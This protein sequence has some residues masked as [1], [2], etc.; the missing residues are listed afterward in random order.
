[1][2]NFPSPF[3]SRLMKIALIVM[4]VLTMIV[5]AVF[6]IT[7]DAVPPSLEYSKIIQMFETEQV[8]SF[9]LTGNSLH[10]TLKEPYQESTEF[11]KRLMDVDLFFD[12]LG[13][14]IHRQLA[15]GTLTEYDYEASSA[16]DRF[17]IAKVLIL[18]L[19]SG[20][21]MYAMFRKNGPMAILADDRSYAVDDKQ[22]KKTFA[23]VAGC[24]EE[25]RACQEIVDFLKKPAAY[26][27]MGARLPKGVLLVGPPGTG[28]TLMAKAVAGEAGVSFLSVS[29]AE[30]EEK[31]VGVGASR[32]RRLFSEAKKKAPA[33][34][35]IDEIDAIGAARRD[36]KGNGY[37]DS[38]QT[39]NQLLTE[40]DGFSD[41]EGIVVMAAT[42]RADILDKALLRSGRFDRQMY[43]GLPDVRE[44]EEILHIHALNKPL[45]EEIDLKTVACSTSGF[46]GADLEKLLNEAAILAVRHERDYITSCD[47]DDAILKI[48]VGL[49]KKGR[50]ISHKER[51]LTAYHE[52]GHAIAARYLKHVDPVHYITIVPRGHVGGF[53]VTRPL[54]DRT[55]RM[56]SDIFEQIVMCLGG[57]TAETM[58]FGETS[59]G[60]AEDIRQATRLV[61]DMVVQ[62][63]MSD[64]LG[65]ICLT[66]IDCEAA[67]LNDGKG[68][69]EE[70]ASMID[71]E[72]RRIF[73][74]ASSH[75]EEIL[76]K[77]RRLL[78]DVAEYLLE[79]E[80]MNGE[81][82]EHFCEHGAPP[83]AGNT[84]TQAC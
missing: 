62:Y 34:V 28:K 68:Y 39:L 33:I 65:P 55:V 72:I 80:T 70:T 25:K 78:I 56:Q 84:K 37:S 15:D 18:L 40:M 23:D 3:S 42:N 76:K 81:E 48:S 58:F 20:S 64:C 22:K 43:I 4:G 63:G 9:S 57:R 46:S 53:M 24:D 47:V 8:D 69:S 35:F 73:D 75:C 83:E 30:F 5:F 45:G 19:L 60:A 32:V 11:T 10:L 66:G 52:A 51:C 82:F 54:E 67:G 59:T 29:G 14:T 12:D 31:Y 74:E 21:F 79:H 26:T 27:R 61:R 1:M 38:E 16:Q 49:Q 41:G 17:V 2:K 13:D 77:H 7:D 6:I 44:R 71:R 36:G 50:V